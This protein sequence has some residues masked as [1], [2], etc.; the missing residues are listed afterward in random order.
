MNHD[1]PS[2]VPVIAAA[3]AASLLMLVF[4]A[5]YRV[6]AARLEAPVTT[7]PMDPAALGQFPLQIGGWTG[8]D[9]PM[10]DAIVRATNTDA[11]INRRY[12]RHNGSEFVWFYVAYGVRA[13]DLMPHRPEVCYTGSGWTLL[14]RRSTELPLS[15]GT[16]LPCNIMRFSRGALNTQRITVLDFYIVDGQ[17]CPDVS[18]LR[19]K[20]WRGSGAVRCVAQVEIAAPIPETVT[21]DSVERGVCTFAV[22]SALPT[23][24][25]FQ[26]SDQNAG[27]DGSYEPFKGE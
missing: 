12:S 13:R 7:V 25:L 8:E 14:D 10:D 1:K 27:S 11:R 23:A 18:L 19:S 9:V 15:D 17:Y 3:A 6:V 16:A 24:R 2:R 21:A 5:T 4:G 22:D 26:D 20:A